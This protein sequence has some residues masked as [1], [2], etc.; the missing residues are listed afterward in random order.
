MLKNY[1]KIALRTIA[2]HKAYSFINIFGLAIGMAS[3]ILILLWVQNELSYDRFNEHADQTYRIVADASGFKAA[4]NCAGMPEGLQAEMPAIRNTV[5]LSHQNTSLFAVGT[6]KFVEKEG[7]FADS[8]F[9]DV[10]SYRLLKGDRRAALLAP[11]AVVITEDMARKYFGKEDPMGKIM[12]RD[13]WNNVRVTGILANVPSNSHLHFN[14]LL[15]TAALANDNDIKTRTWDNFNFYSYV[16]LDKHF[17][18]TPAALAKLDRQVDAI[19]SKHEKNLKVKFHLQPLTDI[20]LYSNGYQV[21]LTGHG[22][23]QYV[24]IFFI[25][26]IFILAVACINFMN[27]ATA[28]SARRA[29]E[30]GLRKVVG[31]VRG[32]LVW[33]FLGESMLIS[34]FALLMAILLVYLALPSFNYLAGKTLSINLW[35]G[36]LLL[37]IVGIAAAT[38]LISGSYPAL[39]LSGFQPVKVLK[40]N[41][42]SLGGNRLF[43]N[44]LV[45]MQFVVSIVLLVGTFV[46]YRQLTYIKER[47][48]G[49]DK[50]NVVYLSMDGKLWDNRQAFR[51]Q[52]AQN[53]LTSEFSV[54]SDLPDNLTTGTENVDWPGKDPKTQII[55]PSMAV[56]E[57]F[58]DMMHMKMVAGRAFSTSFTGDSSNFIINETAVRIMGMTVQNAV[59]QQIKWQG[60]KGTVIGVVQDF[61]FKPIQQAIEPLVIQLN[62][63]GNIVMV[64]A[65]PGTT[66]ATV[67]ALEKMAKQLNPAYPFTYNFLDQTLAKLYTGEQQMGKIFNLFAMLAIFISCLGLYGL[68]AYMAEQRTKEIGVRKVLGASLFNIVRLL[69]YDFTR[70][71]VVAMII[72]IPLSWW[73]VNSWLQG[74]AYHVKM[75]WLIFLLAPL[76]AL[77]IAWITV[78]YESVRAAVV[79]PSKSLRSGE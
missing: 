52:L 63:W 67:K 45:V 27:L 50:E 29:K 61:N 22:N 59:G 8:T 37:M 71:I 55:I 16:V 6:Q 44:G 15:S 11:D 46:V 47:N 68:S 62:K 53:S 1:L 74:F 20:H 72:A 51:A 39:F 7:F 56:S 64:R 28:R 38:G 19:Y 79:N 18:P 69:S 31:A 17:D 43:R 41:L 3:S 49:F 42:R 65:R 60:N 77:F 13:G 58:F 54:V 24:N 32:Q 70:L 66:E 9:F 48:M 35:D 5:R 75:G 78:S 14:Y 40:G 21:D 30:V 73:A 33:Q 76:T 25:V 36:K 4:V 57:S 2:R 26:A 23:V 34:L 10:F 12:Q